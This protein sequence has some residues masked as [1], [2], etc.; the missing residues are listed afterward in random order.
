MGETIIEKSGKVRDPLKAKLIIIESLVFLIPCFAVAY[1]SYQKRISFDINQV[2]ILLA[3]LCIILGG[4]LILRQIFDRILLLQNLMKKA[5]QG[6]QYYMD[7]QK[8]AG[9]L[10]QIT[11]SFN[12]LMTNF[13]EAN[14][15]LQSRIM[16]IADLKRE[17]EVLQRAKN[18]AEAANTAKSRFM[19]NMSH[20]FLTP[21]NSVIGFSQILKTGTHGDLNEKQKK[22]V[23]NILES[24]QHLLKLV[25]NILEFSKAEVEVVKF[26]LSEFDPAEEVR[27]IGDMIKDSAEKKGIRLVLDIQEN[28][29]VINADREKF[30]QIVLNLLNNAV[31]FTPAHGKILLAAGMADRDMIQFND[32]A[33]GE[34]G[35]GTT[36]DFIQISVSD[37]GIGIKA[38]D[39]ERIFSVF[40][41]ADGSVKRIFDGTGLGLAMCR[42]YVE[43][44]KGRIWVES[45]GEGQGSKFIFI[46]PLNP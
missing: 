19:A 24:G 39:R 45:E 2:L 44:H 20:E 4:M 30:G 13:K 22:Y 15:E 32:Q 5:E 9:E 17:E 28:L 12:S 29:P 18:S 31:K 37:N 16:E 46:L 42:R 34:Q 25:N 23:N 6:E 35:T 7:I 21:L 38:E 10:Y 14:T 33:I 41:Q 3:V 1:I 36:E 43:L 27:R 26:D 8:D 11:A 40:E